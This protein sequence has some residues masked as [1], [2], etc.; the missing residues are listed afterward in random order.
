MLDQILR[1]EN[2][3]NLYKL[4]TLKVFLYSIDYYSACLE[5]ENLELLSHL[6]I[7]INYLCIIY[8]K[9]SFIAII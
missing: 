6:D 2:P 9:Y 4:F 8:S 3:N 7:E 1:Q 5:K